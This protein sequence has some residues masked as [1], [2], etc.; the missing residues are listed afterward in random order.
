MES[1]PKRPNGDFRDYKRKVKNSCEFKQSTTANNENGR[2][3]LIWLVAYIQ[4]KVSKFKYGNASKCFV[5][6]D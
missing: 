3:G 5:E 6:R 2:F 1:K 4:T